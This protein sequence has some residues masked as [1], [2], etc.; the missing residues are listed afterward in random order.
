MFSL[1][2]PIGIMGSG[3]ST[4]AR[5]MAAENPKVKIV[6]P[7]V[8]REM[9]N[10]G[11]K[12]HAELDSMIDCTVIYTTHNLLAMKYD[13]II[14]CCNLMNERR[15]KWIK[16]VTT[17]VAGMKVRFVAV[18]FPNKD[19]QWHVD[20]RMK[21]PH[22]SYTRKEWENVYDLHQK[23]FEPIEEDYDEVIYKESF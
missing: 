20:N 23:Q 21:E 18:I 19:K 5:K 12:Y 17:Y 9:L 1:Y 10:G 4:W 13:V 16:G 15:R 6:S 22:G 11:Y 2:I 8:I 7:D 14:D 3:K